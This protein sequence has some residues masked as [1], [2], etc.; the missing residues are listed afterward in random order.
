W[1]QP[2]VREGRPHSGLEPTPYRSFLTT[3]I[4]V[5]RNCP[6]ELCGG[7]GGGG[8]ASGPGPPILRSSS[9]FQ[10]SPTFRKRTGV[11]FSLPSL[12]FST[13]LPEAELPSTLRSFRATSPAGIRVSCLPGNFFRVLKKSPKK[14]HRSLTAPARAANTFSISFSLS[15]PFG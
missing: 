15:P 1:F 10:P 6:R 7:G 2:G 4:S 11:R 5:D 8:A 13:M 9:I 3:L 12:I 14:A